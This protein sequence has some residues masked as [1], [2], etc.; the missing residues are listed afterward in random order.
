MCNT[1]SNSY[2]FNQFCI[3]SC[4]KM[5][6]RIKRLKKKKSQGTSKTELTCDYNFM[7]TDFMSKFQKMCEDEK[8]K[9]E[10]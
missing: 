7:P 9:N 2:D 3:S 8:C 5:M 10:E 6:V 4:L 1:I